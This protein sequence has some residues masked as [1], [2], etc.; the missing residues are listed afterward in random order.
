MSIP[1]SENREDPL[2][3]EN[4][5]VR[6]TG[7]GNEVRALSSFTAAVRAG[8]VFALVGE[9]GSGKS[10]AGFAGGGLL[11]ADRTVV[12][13]RISLA[14]EWLEAG[15]PRAFEPHRG[16]RIGFVF[17]EPGSALHPAMTIRAQVAEAIHRPLGRRDRREAVRRLL[18]SVRLEPDRR[19]LGAYPHH[20]SGGMQQRVV[21]AMAMANDPPALIADEPT[22]A[23]DPTIRRGILDLLRA[24]ALE[25]RAGVLLISHDLGI[26]H[27]FSDRMAVLHQGRIVEAGSTGEILR[28]PRHEHTRALLASARCE[29]T[30]VPR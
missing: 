29:T 9:S 27:K 6:F 21:L 23:L 13:G 2:R 14:G 5:S 20:L 3:F 7:A 28:K 12:S 15:D 11:P 24:H 19:I 18:R 17:Q 1:A 22:T 16:R 8:E 10:T 30:E 25:R 4:V 26:V